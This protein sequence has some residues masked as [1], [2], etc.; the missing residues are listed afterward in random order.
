MRILKIDWDEEGEFLSRPN[1]Y[2][3]EVKL[4][5][6]IELVHVHDPGRLEELLYKGNKVL[7]KRA[8]NPNRKTNWDVIAAKKD[9]EWILINSAY[10]R[11][12]GDKLLIN[13]LNQLG[14]LDTIRAEVKYKNSRLDYLVT[15]DN[16]NIWI[17]VK[18]CTLSRDEI[19]IF[20]DAPTKRGVKHLKELMELKEKGERAGLYIFVLSK[21]EKFMPNWET[22]VEFAENFYRALKSGV[23][24]YPIQFEYKNS[25]IV[26]K[27][28][29]EIIKRGV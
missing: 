9:E 17:E 19:A 5:D 24:I 6:K 10:H 25:W 11:K 22:D 26:Y 12:I 29:L 3:A 18:G 1:R 7:I 28:V 16:K 8:A 14:K 2:L 27:K 21:A 20:P 23:E 15:K 13:N 4:G